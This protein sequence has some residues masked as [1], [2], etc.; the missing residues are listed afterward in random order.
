MTYLPTTAEAKRYARRYFA[1]LPNDSPVDEVG[2][3]DK[4]HTTYNR[5]MPVA[6]N[7]DG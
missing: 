6:I 7:R 5:V 2:Y 3:A 4:G 1:S